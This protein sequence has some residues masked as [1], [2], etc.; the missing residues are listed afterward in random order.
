MWRKLLCFLQLHKWHYEDDVHIWRETCI[1]CS[2]VRS[3]WTY[4]P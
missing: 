1:H 3:G 2:A 4:F